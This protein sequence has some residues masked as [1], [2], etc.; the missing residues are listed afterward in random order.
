MHAAIYGDKPFGACYPGY[1]QSRLR[2][3][4]KRNTGSGTLRCIAGWISLVAATA[5]CADPREVSYVHPDYPT[6]WP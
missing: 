6:T 4:T 2:R 1:L 5:A 3:M